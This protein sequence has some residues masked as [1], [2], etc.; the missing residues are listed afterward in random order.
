MEQLPHFAHLINGGNLNRTEKLG[1][2]QKTL[3]HR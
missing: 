1:H 2:P 3:R